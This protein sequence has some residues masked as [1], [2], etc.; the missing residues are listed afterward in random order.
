M[1]QYINGEIKNNS[2]RVTF[3]SIL[4]GGKGIKYSVSNMLNLR[5]RVTQVEMLE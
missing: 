2:E 1:Q 5:Y 4:F 3:F